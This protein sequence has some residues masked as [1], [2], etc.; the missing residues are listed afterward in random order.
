MLILA[1]TILNSP[2]ASIESQ[3]KIGAV[4]KIIID[5]NTGEIIAFGVAPTGFFVSDKALSAKDVLDVDKNGVVTNTQ[6]NLV[7]VDEIVRIKELQKERITIIGQKAV[8]ESK[9]NLGNIYDYLIETDTLIILKYYIKS[10]FDERIL[11][12]DKVIKIDKNAVVFSNDVIEQTPQ[13]EVEGA[14]A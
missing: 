1:S 13:A 5:P 6:E 7:E 11:P 4:K 2:V 14:A 8:T 3:S 12:N 10:L 9:K